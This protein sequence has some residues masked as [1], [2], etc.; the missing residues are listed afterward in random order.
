[1]KRKSYAHFALIG[2][3]LLFAHLHLAAQNEQ[4]VVAYITIQGVTQGQ[5]KGNVTVKERQGQIECI[6]FSYGVTAPTDK[7]SGLTTGKRQ[8]SPIVIVKR[9]DAA[10]PQLLQAAY[11]NEQLK[12]VTIEFTRKGPD[13]RPATFQTIQLTNASVTK[14]NQ[15]AGTVSPDKLVPNSL[16][17]EEIDLTFEK[18]DVSDTDAKTHAGDSWGRP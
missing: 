3:F 6:G 17:L 9:V 16:P 14:V 1:M 8:H 18:I 10:T 4:P 13:G 5:F 12:S 11:S 2:L 7:S 15:F